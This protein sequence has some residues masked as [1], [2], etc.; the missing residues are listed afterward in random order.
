MSYLEELTREQFLANIENQRTRES[1][2]T[3]LNQF[4]VFCNQSFDKEGDFVIKDVK[5][6]IIQ[7]QDDCGIYRLLQSF[8]NWLNEDHLELKIKSRNH[9]RPMVKRHPTTVKNYLS[10]VKQYVEEFWNIDIIDRKYHKR[11]TI[12]H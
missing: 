8:V 11:V 3:A 1:Y 2:L 6:R 12:F 4:D 10:C 5:N 9:T 7:A